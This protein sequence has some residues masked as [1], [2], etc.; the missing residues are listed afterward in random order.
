MRLLITLLLLTLAFLFGYNHKV[1][2]TPLM[3]FNIR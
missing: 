1:S 2:T 3:Q